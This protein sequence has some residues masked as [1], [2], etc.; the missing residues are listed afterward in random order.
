MYIKRH[1]FSNDAH[2]QNLTHE[3]Y[4]VKASSISNRLQEWPL[5]HCEF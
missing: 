3:E 1:P 5:E 2:K 4:K